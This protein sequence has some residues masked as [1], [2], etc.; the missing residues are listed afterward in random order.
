MRA[1]LRIYRVAL[2]VAAA[3]R[4]FQRRVRDHRGQLAQAA[5]ELRLEGLVLLE[6]APSQR[7]VVTAPRRYAALDHL[8]HLH[9]NCGLALLL[10]HAAIP[11]PLMLQVACS[12]R[13]GRG[14][15]IAY[16]RAMLPTTGAAAD[17][18]IPH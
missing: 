15:L 2:H 13:P 16:H 11:E 3:G 8:V 14:L 4:L 17:L 5:L 12:T 6:E 7:D 1:I 10:R 18:H 9:A